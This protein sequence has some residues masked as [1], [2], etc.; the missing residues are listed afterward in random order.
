MIFLLVCKRD[1]H[2][3]S[4]VL[5]AIPAIIRLTLIVFLAALKTVAKTALTL[6]ASPLI[7]LPATVAVTTSIRT[8]PA[9]AARFIIAVAT[10]QQ[11]LNGVIQRRAS[12]KRRVSKCRYRRAQTKTEGN[13]RN[14]VAYF[15]DSLLIRDPVSESTIA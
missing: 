14:Q 2:C 3:P 7:L 10:Y 9:I 13:E 15:H 5:L 1:A 6:V 4:S 11:N 8:I 12:I